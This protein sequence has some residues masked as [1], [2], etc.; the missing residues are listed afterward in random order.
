MEEEQEVSIKIS[1]T[2]YIQAANLTLILGTSAA[3]FLKH[4]SDLKNSGL[5][6]SVTLF[7]SSNYIGGRSTVCWPWSL[8]PY[9]SDQPLEEEP[10]ELGASIFIKG[11]KNLWKAA[12]EFN[13][14][15]VEHKGEDDGA[16][17]VWNGQEVLYSQS[18]GGWGWNVVKMLWRYGRSPMKVST[19]V[20][21]TVDS[22]N[23]LY[24]SSFVSQGPFT[25]LEAFAN[26]TSL[27]EPFATTSQEYFTKNG[28][29]P[30]FTNELV[31]AA[32]TVN[33]GTP[34]SKIHGVG[35]L[36]SL[37]AEGAMSVKGGNRKI[38]QE[39]LLRSDAEVKMGK[40]GTVEEI[41]K[42]D[43]IDG[44]KPQWV[45]RTKGGKG[46]TFDVSFDFFFFS[47]RNRRLNLF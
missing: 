39:F 40:E 36:V 21:S 20:K 46:S 1:A 47:I 32:S 15:L 38:F 45:V 19:L 23:S 7:E 14:T 18:T 16:F 24:T 41:I 27:L 12:K 25:S 4:F 2:C 28:V 13:L 26:S 29:N 33:Y 6:T 37:A 3:F 43:S 44:A 8:N 30:L 11:N 9:S 5:A 10:V 17:S 35:A 22:F 42:L 34:S 31:S